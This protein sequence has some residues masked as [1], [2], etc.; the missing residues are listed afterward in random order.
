MGGSEA[1]SGPDGSIATRTAVDVLEASEHLEAGQ[2]WQ[3]TKSVGQPGRRHLVDPVC[4]A[5]QVEDAAP[6]RA[7]GTW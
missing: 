4:S 6:L 5:T 1:A 2:E 7:F 3:G